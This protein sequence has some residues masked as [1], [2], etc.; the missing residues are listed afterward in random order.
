MNPRC[1]WDPLTEPDLGRTRVESF[2]AASVALVT[3]GSVTLATYPPTGT[4]REVPLITC[5]MSVLCWVHEWVQKMVTWNLFRA[6][7][8]HGYDCLQRARREQNHTRLKR[9]WSEV[10]WRRLKLV[11]SW[12]DRSQVDQRVNAFFVPRR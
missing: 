8:T 7:G 1:V 2:V 10:T 5:C 9:Q 3:G 4:S 11:C 6:C 12:V